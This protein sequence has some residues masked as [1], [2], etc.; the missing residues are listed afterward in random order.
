MSKSHYSEFRS[1][2][3]DLPKHAMARAF[4]YGVPPECLFQCYNIKGF[5]QIKKLLKLK[6]KT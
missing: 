5:P 2:L 6:E 1:S 3:R 4:E